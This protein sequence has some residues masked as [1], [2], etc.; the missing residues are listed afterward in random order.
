[1]YLLNDFQQYSFTRK[2]FRVSRNLQFMQARIGIDYY[3]PLPIEG[4]AGDNLPKTLQNQFYNNAPFVNSLLK[5]M[6]KFHDVDHEMSINTTNFS[7]NERIYDVTRKDA[8]LMERTSGPGIYSPNIG[9]YC[10]YENTHTANGLPYYYENAYLGKCVYAIPFETL[11]NDPSC[12]SGVNTKNNTPFELTIKADQ[13]GVSPRVRAA[14]M[15]IFCYYDM[16]IE[17][18]GGLF[19]VLG[20]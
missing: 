17:I 20:R 16:L 19:K 10:T 8:F 15:I 9:N 13:N 18:K 2:N 5:S 12:I 1:M 4:E 7:L 6:N 14:I 3:P 11:R